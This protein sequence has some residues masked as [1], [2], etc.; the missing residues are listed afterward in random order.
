M[1]PIAANDWAAMLEEL[2]AL[3]VGSRRIS[4]A[5]GGDVTDR[6][7]RVYRNGTQPTHWRGEALVALWCE[8]TGKARELAPRCDVIRGHRA[9]SA[10]RD[11]K[12]TD[13]SAGYLAAWALIG[14]KQAAPK[15]TGRRKVKVEG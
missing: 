3:G 6:M 7:L 9:G 15:K 5:M 10:P 8:L 11:S 12:H 13:Y 14:V 1:K 2:A 4:D